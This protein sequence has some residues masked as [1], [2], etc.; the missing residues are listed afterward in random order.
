MIIG[1]LYRLFAVA[2]GGS[3]AK[4]CLTLDYN[5]KYVDIYSCHLGWCS[6]K[7]KRYEVGYNFY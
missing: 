6:D 7:E 5:N 4:D 1:N 2:I 3:L